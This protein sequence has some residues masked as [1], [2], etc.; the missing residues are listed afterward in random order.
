MKNMTSTLLIYTFFIP[1]LLLATQGQ[2]TL[3]N[4]RYKP[5]I[6]NTFP[7]KKFSWYKFFKENYTHYKF[8]SINFRF[9]TK[10]S[11]ILSRLQ[12]LDNFLPNTVATDK[13]SPLTID[14]DNFINQTGEKVRFWGVNL[15]AFYPT[16]DIADKTAENLSSLGVNMVRPHHMM[17]YGL[18]W[19]PTME[20]GALVDYKED[21]R[22]FDEDALDKFDYLNSALRNE[23]IY[24]AFALRWSRSYHE[25]DVKII[26]TTPEDEA[27]W[28]EGWREIKSWDW[29]KQ[30][31]V[32]K[33]LSLIDE[34]FIAIDEEFATNILQHVNP[35]TQLSYAKDPQV[36]TIEV[37]NEYGAEYTFICNN[38]FPQYFHD[39]LQSKWDEYS[40]KYGVET[41][42]FYSPE[43]YEQ[44][45]LRLDFLIGLDEMRMQRMIE[46][47]RDLGYKGSITYSNLFRG[48]NLLSMQ[49]KLANHSENHIY[50]TPFVVSDRDDFFYQTNKALL[51]DKPFIVSEFNI[52]E[53]SS[54]SAQ[55][56]PNRTMLTAAATAY[57]SFHNWSGIA[58]FSWQHGTNKVGEDGWS[59]EPGRSMSLGDMVKDEM[60]LDHFKTASIIYRNGY[61][62]AA[63]PTTL[64]IDA[65]YKFDWY[66][67]IID[68]KYLYKQGW[69]SIHSIRKTFDMGENENAIYEQNTAD[70]M[71]DTPNSPLI[72]DTGQ[73]IKDI[74]REQLTASSAKAEIYS[75]YFDETLP[76]G[77]RFMTLN[78]REG[79]ATI[80]LTSNDGKALLN[81]E[82]LLISKTYL[83]KDYEETDNITIFLNTQ[84]SNS[85]WRMKV[86]RPFNQM[87]T[88]ELTSDELGALNLP[89]TQWYLAKIE[90]VI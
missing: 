36:A 30:H 16:P 14:G 70:W 54:L 75:G 71:N 89:K 11:S 34:R 42:E 26:E 78:Q 6:E 72:T 76:L 2:A 15:T 38:K 44:R 3:N 88:I 51:K 84:K 49:D 90:Q 55:Y 63:E 10:V 86:L 18:D 58:W 17:R 47:T 27:A 21:S 52:T 33:S 85:K 59:V 5:I 39:K 60:Q 8:T 77:L 69:Q 31:D 29:Q 35:Y 20:S 62:Q 45:M 56:E 50:A 12:Y 9:D 79:F 82:N 66:Y 7:D 41:S 73:I 81:S 87:R 61:I 37:I 74:E 22:E 4:Q 28:L 68:G 23:G 24:L 64:I 32:V 43:S 19:N 40:I 46:L 83:D 25:G 80:L 67:G 13:I 53:D 48:E 1:S 65:P 57:A